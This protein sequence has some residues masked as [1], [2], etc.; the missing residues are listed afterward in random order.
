MPRFAKEVFE[1]LILGAMAILQQLSPGERSP[2]GCPRLAACPDG[3]VLMADTAH[4][5][6][7]E[8]IVEWAYTTLPQKIR[9]CRISPAFKWLTSLLRTYWRTYR[10]KGNGV[11]GTE[12]LGLY[13]GTF[14]TKQ[15]FSQVKYAPD[16]IFVF[17][18]PI[19]RCS[20]GD[21]RA[22]VETGGVA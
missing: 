9:T 22:E 10:T 6:S 20:K 18:G 7:F 13:S 11:V 4:P 16:L 17:R 5:E 1:H 15:S 21:L 2:A 19:L 8:E 14:R 3:K 12:L